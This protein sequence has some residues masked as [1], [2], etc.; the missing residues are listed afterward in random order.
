MK[1]RLLFALPALLLVTPL[2]H[3]QTFEPGLLVRANGDT[4]RGEIENGF[5]V[6]APEFIRYRATPASPSQLLQPRQLRAVSFTNGRYFRYEALP[7]NHAA[8]VQLSRLPHGYTTD[9]RTDSLLAEVLLEGPAGLLRTTYQGIAHYLI[10]RS[11]QPY[12]ELSEQKYLRETTTGR[13]EVANGNNYQGQLELYFGDC[14]A[15]RTAAAAA[16]FTVQGLAAVVQAYNQACAPTAPPARSWLAQAIPRRRLALQGGLVAGLRYSSFRNGYESLPETLPCTDCQP[17]PFAGLYAD[18]LHPGRTRAL[19]GELS[20]SRFSNQSYEYYRLNSSVSY[21]VV[22][23]RAWLFSAR[24]GLR[25]FF[26]LPHERQ[27]LLSLAYELNKS[28]APTI[29]S[30]TGGPVALTNDQLGYGFP[31]LLPSLGLGWRAQRCTLSLDGQLYTNRNS[32]GAF[33][34]I[35]GTNFVARAGIAYRL[36]RNP[37]SATH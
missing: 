9:V 21:Y 27:W 34:G 25:F 33:S 24:L 6:D 3:A 5:W 32:E 35:I 22:D 29:T 20:L 13:R 15:A 10:R 12:L 16:P 1:L 28:F 31:S 26:P 18:L 8:E 19:Y 11:G 2:S 4:L 17:R 14:P 30:S 7:I 23:Y 37:D 36:G